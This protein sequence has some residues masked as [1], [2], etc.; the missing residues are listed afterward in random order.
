MLQDFRQRFI[1]SLVATVP[2]LLLSPT[3]QQWL[4]FS[5]EF[6]GSTYLLFAVST[7]IFVYGGWPFLRG[8]YRELSSRQPGMMT[9]IAVAISVA[10]FYSAAVVFGLPGKYFFWELATLIDVMLLGH[11]IEMRSVMSASRALEKLAQLMPDVAHRIIDGDTEDV[12]VD[13]LREG[14]RLLVKPGEKIPADGVVTAG[15]SYVNEAMLTGESTPVH[16]EEGS[17]VIGGAVNGDGSLEIRVQHTGE[18]SYLSKV[19]DLVE[20]A[21][22]SQSSTQRLADRA[23]FWLTLVALTAGFVTLAA[24]LLAGQSF[25]FSIERMATVM[26]ITCPHALGLAIPLVV[27]VSTTL[28][29]R[30]GLLIRNRTAF[31]N[32]RNITAVVFDKTG[33]L[34][35]GTFAVST[36]QPLTDDYDEAA[37]L[38]L[39]ASLEQR[40]EHPIAG[41]VIDA[42]EQR[43]LP[44]HDVVGFQAIKGEG[45]EGE[46]DGNI[47]RIVSPSS[48]EQRGIAR[49]PEAEQGAATVVYVLVDD[50]PAG[51]ITL[52]DSLRPQSKEAIRRLKEAGIACWMLT[53]DTER[54]AAVVAD[55]LDLDGY[56]AGVLPHEKQEKIRELQERGAV[57]AMTGD[58]IN[59]APALAQADVGIA[60]GSGTD[61]AAETADIILVDSDPMDVASL[62]LFG[63]ATYGK[64]V[65]NLL[66]ATGYNVVA[67]PLAAGVL[68][69]QG[70][71][72]SPAAGAILMSLSTIIVAINARLLS[73]PEE[74]SDGHP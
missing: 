73:M 32:A 62:I 74:E 51:I 57:V 15:D 69:N 33:T 50:E 38:Q 40:S 61:V 26:V 64:M 25:V 5:L 44:L 14:D 59:D 70:V 49:H 18:D 35:E 1:V 21:Q 9:L 28:S 47:V 7:F 60:I 71:V 55:E 68:Y 34:T 41:A 2:V 8:L 52:S 19:I 66:W 46:V 56:F 53:G 36:V 45:I 29:A 17:E 42:A 16:K 12:P 11:W 4:G 54:A 48:L 65:Q 67:I 3:I 72:I 23:A 24:W 43:D 37:I 22:A 31:E 13:E 63:R 39:A 27:A 10:Y 6:P 20:Q 58:G 30:H